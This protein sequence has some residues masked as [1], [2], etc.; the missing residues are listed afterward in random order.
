VAFVDADHEIDRAWLPAAAEVLAAPDVAVTGAPCLVPPNPTWVQR[1]YDAMR[2]RLTTATEVDWL[3]SGNLAVWRKDFDLVAGF[4]ETLTAC[5]DV[6]FC[7]RVR[8]RGRRIVADPRL[9]NV[10]FGDPAT[11]RAL[12]RGELWRGRDNLIVTFRG[13]RTVRHLRSAIAPILTL[14]A[15]VLSLI[16]LLVGQWAWF[17]GLL[18]A[19][20]LPSLLN[21]WRMCRRQRQFDITTV[22]QTLAVAMVFDQARALALLFRGSHRARRAN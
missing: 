2:P 8:L 4:D 15:L 10:H 20:L 22:A 17:L 12:F 18:I 16:A 13:P 6:D 7:N 14:G 9:R 5:E 21:T 3:G 1:R 11:L 19:A